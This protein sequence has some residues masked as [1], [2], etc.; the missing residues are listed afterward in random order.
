MARTK[1]SPLWIALFIAIPLCAC[2][3][4]EKIP[5]AAP[6]ATQTAEQST[7]PT[8]TETPVPSPVESEKPIITAAPSAEPIAAEPPAPPLDISEE[9]PLDD[10]SASIAVP[11]FLTGEQQDL[12][13]RAHCL[14][15]NLFGA[16]PACVD[17]LGNAQNG[18]SNE[19]VVI[20]D[21]TYTLSHGRYRSWADF[22]ALVHAVFTE[23]FWDEHNSPVPADG[24]PW[25]IFREY[26]GSLCYLD[27]EKG[28]GYYYNENFPDEFR[29]ESQSEDRILFTLIG[30]YSWAWP[31]EGETFEE[32]DAR[33]AREY[34]YTIEF[35]IRMV[36]TED[37]WRFDVFHSALVDENFS[38]QGRIIEDDKVSYV[39]ER[40]GFSMEFPESWRG[41]LEA[42]QNYDISWGGWGGGHCITFY[43]SFNWQGQTRP[44]G[45]QRACWLRF[46][47]CRATARLRTAALPSHPLGPSGVRRS[48]A[49][50]GDVPGKVVDEALLA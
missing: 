13:R 15:L 23:E 5:E 17:C 44:R 47:P 46:R 32:R 20:D 4:A 9:P 6:S 2:Q 42:E 39:D 29:L 35:P 19:T 40:L 37:G 50:A 26:N 33:R 21:M 38:P 7:E 49:R 10:F 45:P 18:S 43:H 22:N 27:T 48:F 16:A 31:K 28:Q 11:D 41:K 1:K 34:E 24:K 12:Y 30:H 14:Y 36:L 25:I 8:V 3:T